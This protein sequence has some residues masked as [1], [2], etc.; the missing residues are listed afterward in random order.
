[1]RLP[2]SETSFYKLF[3][4]NIERRGLCRNAGKLT[5]LLYIVLQKLFENEHVCEHLDS[6]HFQPVVS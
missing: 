2:A 5:K 1:M 3:S 6:S 4:E